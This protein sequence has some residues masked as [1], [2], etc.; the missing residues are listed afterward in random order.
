MFDAVLFDLDNTLLNRSAAWARFFCMRGLEGRERE[1]ALM[2]DRSGEE[3]RFEL[4]RWLSQRFPE[5]WPRPMDALQDASSSVPEM[6]D[7]ADGAVDVLARLRERTRVGFVT[8]G[9]PEQRDLAARAR[10]LDDVDACVVSSEAGAE[11]PHPRPFLKALAAL[12]ARPQETAFVGDSP[13]DDI[14]GARSLGMFTVWVS[15]GRQWPAHLTPP[16]EIVVR[17]ADVEGALGLPPAASA[18]A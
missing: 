16:D 3:D 11:K 5:R 2:R 14:E 1:L 12:S 9:G 4:S 18:H 8:N 17:I 7:A 10:L 6:I 15:H 13:E